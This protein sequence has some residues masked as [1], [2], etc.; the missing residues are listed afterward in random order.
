MIEINQKIPT[1]IRSDHTDY[2]R[3]SMMTLT[4]LIITDQ[5]KSF[6][7]YF[8]DDKTLAGE[9]YTS[10]HLIQTENGHTK[11]QCKQDAPQDQ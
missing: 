3:I 6:F 4:H 8:C 9:S 7:G 10:H 2:A 1:N 5:P 11:A